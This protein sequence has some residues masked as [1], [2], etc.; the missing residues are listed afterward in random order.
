MRKKL[1]K[2]NE[3]Y[4]ALEEMKSQTDAT[5]VRLEFM[6]FRRSFLQGSI[7]S[8]MMTQN[9]YLYTLFDSLKKAFNF[10]LGTADQQRC[11]SFHLCTLYEGKLKTYL[12]YD[13]N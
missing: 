3:K 4:I 8:Y 7:F 5:L 10:A 2:E 6:Q 9:V 12:E 1:L 11:D 13:Q